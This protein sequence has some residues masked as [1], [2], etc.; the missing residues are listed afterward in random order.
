MT[1]NGRG[2]DV[3]V[4]MPLYAGIRWDALERLSDACAAGF[5]S[6]GVRRGD[7]VALVMCNR[8]EMMEGYVAVVRAGAVGV[9]LSTP[10]LGFSDS[11]DGRLPEV[12]AKV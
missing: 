2:F 11:H 8:V 7:R 12:T 5:D 3:R 4:V 6:L 1:F 9:P 10:V